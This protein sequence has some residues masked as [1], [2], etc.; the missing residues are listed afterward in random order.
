MSYLYK[1]QHAHSNSD[2]NG[3]ADGK[4]R[5]N[6]PNKVQVYHWLIGVVKVVLLKAEK[7]PCCYLLAKWKS[8]S[9]HNSCCEL[10]FCCMYE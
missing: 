9:Y 3:E 6:E 5:T 10:T 4:H 7:D 8:W 2:P 1:K